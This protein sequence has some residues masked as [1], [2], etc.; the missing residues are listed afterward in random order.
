MT[1]EELPS[2]NRDIGT[3]YVTRSYL[4]KKVTYFPFLIYDILPFFDRSLGSSFELGKGRPYGKGLFDIGISGS[5]VLRLQLDVY[6]VPYLTKMKLC[7]IIKKESK[8]E[9]MRV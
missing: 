3:V 5:S 1:L 9:R 6:L 2:L 7:I 4:Q 8:G